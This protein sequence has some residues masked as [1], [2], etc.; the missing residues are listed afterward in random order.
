M[1]DREK[2]IWKRLGE[3]DIA[4]IYSNGIWG[5][6]LRIERKGGRRE[7]ARK[8]YKVRTRNRV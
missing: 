1:E 4:L 3:K 8:I 7:N 2:E 5:R 6:S